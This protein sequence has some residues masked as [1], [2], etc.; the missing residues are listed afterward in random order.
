VNRLAYPLSIMQLFHEACMLLHAR[1][2]EGLDLGANGVDEIVVLDG[3][4]SYL[5]LDLRAVC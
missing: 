1:N 3:S 5:A 2:A 4:G